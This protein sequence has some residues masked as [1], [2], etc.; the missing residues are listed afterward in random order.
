[1]I[2]ILTGTPGTGK[3]TI[4]HLLAEKFGC[5]LVDINLLVDEKHLY[6]GLD[7]E[8]GYKVV[9]MVALEEEI[10]RILNEEV[11]DDLKGR[12]DS[13]GGVKDSCVLIE[14][15]L[16]H[17]FPKADFV[18]VFRTEPP[19][20]GNRLQKRGWKDVKIR[21]NLEAEALDVCT[22]EAYQLHGDKVHEV[23]T[24]NITPQK[25][26]DTVLDIINGK[27]SLPPGSID[28]SAFLA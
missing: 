11:E 5:K 23:D 24:S 12:K 27:K 9:D 14:G 28:F 10:Q 7:P 21:E 18:V 19:L 26:V 20:L 25:A 15:H 6:T 8:K 4:S 3:T 1:M 17:N 2:I 16:S 22:W 13:L